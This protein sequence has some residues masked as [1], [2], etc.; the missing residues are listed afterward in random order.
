MRE[1]RNK[2]LTVP[3]VLMGYYNPMLAY[4]E[5]ESIR[6]AAAAGANGF[7]VVDLPPSEAHSFVGSCRKYK[8]AF[9]PL[10]APT[11]EESRLKSISEVAD[12]FI[13]CVSVTGVTGNT[14]ATQSSSQDGLQSFLATVRKYSGDIPLALGFGITDRDAFLRVAPHVNAVVVGSRIIVCIREAFEQ[15]QD[16][17]A[18]VL[19]LIQ[20]IIN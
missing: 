4:G 19:N 20:N 1:A 13:Y 10:V 16:V 7:I 5:E 9:V 15:K 3:I 12:G 18:A 14:N 11:T 6:D 2:G 8:M 17:S